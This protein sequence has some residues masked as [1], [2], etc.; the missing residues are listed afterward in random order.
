[1]T[2]MKTFFRTVAVAGL[3]ICLNACSKKDVEP[4]AQSSPAPAPASP[5]QPQA[6]ATAATTPAPSGAVA[7][8]NVN[9]ALQQQNYDTAV[10]ILLRVKTSSQLTN[11]SQ[12]SL[13]AQQLQKTTM[14]LSQAMAT[15][16]K[17]KAAYE[18]L[19]RAVMGR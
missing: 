18:R 4:S 5:S 11:A 2:D 15:D 7:L 1:M 14:A 10:D 12:S 17:A 3:V 16:P 6:Q 13:Y 8:E 19:G 9:T